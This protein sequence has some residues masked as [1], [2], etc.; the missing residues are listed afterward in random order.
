M[1]LF[2]LIS[3]VDTECMLVL[4][5]ETACLSLIYMSLIMNKSELINVARQHS[6]NIKTVWIRLL[7]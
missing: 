2:G 4:K 6:I 7:I 1:S 3:Y 5:L